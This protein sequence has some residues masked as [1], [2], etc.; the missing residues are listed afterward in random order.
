MGP[1]LPWV[2]VPAAR[3]VLRQMVGH[4]VVDASDSRL[5]GAI[6]HLRTGATA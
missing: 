4:L 5:G 6:R 3:R 1:V 2:V